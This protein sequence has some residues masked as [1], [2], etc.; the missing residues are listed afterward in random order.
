MKAGEY[1]L[2][3]HNGSGAPCTVGMP[4]VVV[5]VYPYVSPV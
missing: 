5:E 1:A 3:A 4:D 2:A